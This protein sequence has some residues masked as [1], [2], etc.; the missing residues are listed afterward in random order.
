VEHPLTGS[1]R[2]RLARRAVLRHDDVRDLDVVLLPERVVKL[3]VTAAEVLRL[4]DGSRTLDRIVLE[5]QARFDGPGLGADV[6]ALL[7]R[8]AER[9]VVE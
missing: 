3:N 7:G 9:G 8:L 2:P 6:V 1:S 5:L 4:C